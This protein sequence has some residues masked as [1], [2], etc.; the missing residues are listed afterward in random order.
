MDNPPGKWVYRHKSTL[1]ICLVLLF[2]LAMMLRHVNQPLLDRHSWRQVDTASFAKGLARGDFDLFH[3]KFLAYY[4]DEFGIEGAT[5]T[6]FNF[7]PLIVAGLYRLLG[8]HDVLA[9]LVSIAFGLGTAFVV[10]LL[11]RRYFDETAGVLA[12]LF[13]GLSPM[14]VFYSRTVQPD[15]TTLFLAVGALYFFLRWLESERWADYV[16]ATL[17][18]MLAFLTKIPSLYMGFPLLYAAWRKYGWRMWR[19]WRIWLF[20]LVALVPALL[21]YLYAHSLYQQT[22]LTVYGITGGWPG[23]GKF[24]NLGQLLSADFYRAMFIRFRSII[25]GN[26]GLLLLALG[27]ALAPRWKEEGVFYVWLGGIGIFILA[28][29]QGNRQHE[30]YQLPVLPVA[31]LF[32]GKALSALLKPGALNLSLILIGQ[33]V[34]ILV[35]A[36]L[37]ILSLRNAIQNAAPL[38][39]QTRVLLEVAEAT[40]RLTPEGAPVAI[41]HDWARVPEV[42]YYAERRGWSLWLERTPQGEYGQ[43]IISVRE[44]T[45]AGWRVQ[46]KRESGIERFELLRAQGGGKPG[47]LA[48]KGHAR[49]VFAQPHRSGALGALSLGGFGGALAR[50]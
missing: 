44:K 22:G 7:Y 27:L 12:A 32:I 8:F 34:G 18:A 4:P 50:L 20:G 11:G 2:V 26:Y 33:R 28:V 23:S 5:E 35:V 13:L 42:F 43:L 6:E 29:A 14:Y 31:A 1:V 19:E 45:P 38:Y 40:R 24:D 49:R 3:P 21:Y 39:Q 46:E 41:L 30:Y 37:L 10:Y 48:G 15:A 9:R 16:A 25:L 36:A 47:R 17:M